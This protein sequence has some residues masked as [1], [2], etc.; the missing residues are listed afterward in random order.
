[1]GKAGNGRQLG[2]AQ[3]ADQ[4]RRQ[5]RHHRRDQAPR[6]TD[7]LVHHFPDRLQCHSH[8]RGERDNDQ[9]QQ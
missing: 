1:M 7:G 2:R 9:E 5:H 3:V 6:R 8:R 4:F